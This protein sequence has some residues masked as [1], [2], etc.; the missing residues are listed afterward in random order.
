M[1]L[2]FFL[3]DFFKGLKK[4]SFLKIFLITRTMYAGKVGV[5]LAYNYCSRVG[6][7]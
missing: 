3:K 5:N 1:L 4:R 6:W 7:G 2:N